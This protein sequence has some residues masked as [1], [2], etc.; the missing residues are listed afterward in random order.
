MLIIKVMQDESHTQKN[1]IISGT[2][3]NVP[4]KK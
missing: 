3:F 2:K 4:K 1:V